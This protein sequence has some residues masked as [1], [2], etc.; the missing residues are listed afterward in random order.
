VLEQGP[1]VDHTDELRR[2]AAAARRILYL[3]DNAGEIVLDRLLIE[4]LPAAEG[5]EVVVAVRGGPTINDATVEDAVAAGLD[6][7]EGVQIVEPGVTLPGIWLEGS[8]PA[9]RR[10]FVEA[11]LILSKGQGNF[12][13]LYGGVEID[14][15]SI[16]FL[17]M[18]KCGVVAR[19]TGQ[20]LGDP[21]VAFGG[22]VPAPDT[23]GVP[24]VNRL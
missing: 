20:E 9:F 6:R 8:S 12:E 23:N 4:Q 14:T 10:F 18:V 24:R 2:R 5:R 7:L 19:A 11:D 3:A 17:F 21:L 16:C 15:R 22:G 1:A 13:T